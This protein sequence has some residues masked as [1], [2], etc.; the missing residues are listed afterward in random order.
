MLLMQCFWGLA[1]AI[2]FINHNDNHND[3]YHP[4]R[5]LRLGLRLRLGST[6]CPK[7]RHRIGEGSALRWRRFGVSTLRARHFSTIKGMIQ[8]RQNLLSAYWYNA[9]FN[10]IHIAGVRY[11]SPRIWSLLFEGSALSNIRQGAT[12]VHSNVGFYQLIISTKG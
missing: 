11:A 1:E 10:L 8:S 6:S 7:A 4:D 3:N 2:L 5:K 12:K 9:L